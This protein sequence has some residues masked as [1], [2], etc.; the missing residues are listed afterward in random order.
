MNTPTPLDDLLFDTQEFAF[1]TGQTFRGLTISECGSGY[2]IVLRA[3]DRDNEPLYAMAQHSDA[4]E[5][6]RVLL[7]ALAT[8]HGP[9]L[10]RHDKFYKGG[11]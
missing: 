9:K 4:R 10:W 2:N 11:S 6:L 3:F 8:R 5:G 7:G 1:L